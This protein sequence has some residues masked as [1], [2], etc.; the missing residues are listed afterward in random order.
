MAHSA[1]PC[2]HPTPACLRSLHA[3]PLLPA[4]LCQSAS[5][6]SP[7]NH[8]AGVRYPSCT[9]QS[10]DFGKGGQAYRCAA[11]ADRTGHAMLHTLYGQAMKHNVQFFGESAVR[12]MSFAS[13]EMEWRALVPSQFMAVFCSALNR[14]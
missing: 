11:A 12:L 13:T 2:L 5:T 1:L 10:L 6:M 4:V 8:P 9:V 7:T 3:L 14:S